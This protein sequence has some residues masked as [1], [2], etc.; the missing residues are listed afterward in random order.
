MSNKEGVLN[1]KASR[2]SRISSIRSIVSRSNSNKC[3]VSRTSSNRS[4]VRLDSSNRGAGARSSASNSGSLS[5]WL[6]QFLKRAEAMLA[7]S[8]LSCL[9]CSGSYTRRRELPLCDAC[10]AAIPWILHN[11]CER[12]G[13]PEVCQDCSRRTET[14]FVQNRSAVSYSPLMKEW[15]GVF[16]YRG[17]ERLRRLL[18]KMLLHAY[19]MHHKYILPSAN[20]STCMELLTFVP[21]S[22]QRLVDRGFNQA[23]QLAEELG[24]LTG[25]PVIGLLERTRHTDKQSFKTRGDRLGD[26]QGAFAVS[27]AARNALQKLECEAPIKVYIIDDVYTTGSTLNECAKVITTELNA[28][29]YGI[30]WAR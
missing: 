6:S 15:L 20:V 14:Y 28:T 30:S 13:R 9:A 16:K 11:R 25:I 7:P 22:E 12:C 19:H 3:I 21:L 4:G 5:R 29:V 1:G 26:L 18:G 10:S 24:H 27:S 17:N 23:Q 8:R 2:T